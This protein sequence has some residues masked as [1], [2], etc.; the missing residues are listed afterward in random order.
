LAL[1]ISVTLFREGV[2]TRFRFGSL[3]D[4]SS[5]GLRR[6]SRDLFG[7]SQFVLNVVLFVPAGATWTLIS[8]RPVLS[9]LALSGF[10]LLIESTQAVTGAG[11]NDVADLAANSLGA[12]IG[13]VMVVVCWAIVDDR[14]IDLST[15]SRRLVVAGAV[16]A[17]LALIA[18]WFVGASTRQQHVEDVLRSKFEGTDRAEIEALMESHSNAVFGAA[19]DYA[20]GTRYSNDTIEIRYPATFFSLHRCVFVVWNSEGVEFRKASGHDC[21]DFIDG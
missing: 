19:D 17:G 7:S 20:N 11:A 16:V 12:A 1:I 9:W 15:R 5:D 18:G 14:V 2:P 21:T 6:L 4:W 13:A 3:G 10:S 8:R